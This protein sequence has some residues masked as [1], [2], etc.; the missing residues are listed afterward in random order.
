[1]NDKENHIN[2]N[3]AE[4]NREN[5]K[6]ATYST[7]NMCACAYRR[8]PSGWRTK[9][10]LGLY[11]TCFIFILCR[12]VYYQYL[13]MWQQ[14]YCFSA[15]AT[16]AVRSS[17]QRIEKVKMTFKFETQQHSRNIHTHRRNKR[18]RRIKR[19]SHTEFNTKMRQGTLLLVFVLLLLAPPLP[20]WL[21]GYFQL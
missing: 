19:V 13:C 2:R 4:Y 21:G 12:I 7:Q 11:S 20:S 14:P 1:M 15:H 10:L 3:G 18:T 17:C 5:G 8:L 16:A 9:V 6:T